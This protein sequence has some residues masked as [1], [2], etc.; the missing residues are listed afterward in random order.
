MSDDTYFHS[1]AGGVVL[2]QIQAETAIDLSAKGWIKRARQRRA[3]A[4]HEPAVLTEVQ[5]LT[6]RSSWLR[7]KAARLPLRSNG[8]RKALQEAQLCQTLALT[9]PV[10]LGGKRAPKLPLGF[11]FG[12][13]RHI[14]R[15]VALLNQL[16]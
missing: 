16:A 15:A 8:R 5:R 9:L 14:Q 10:V 1:A 6:Q 4:Q 12:G 7:R 13:P 2:D 3:R 11:G